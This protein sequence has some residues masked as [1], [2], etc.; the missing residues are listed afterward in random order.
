M[1]LCCQNTANWKATASRVNATESDKDQVVIKRTHNYQCNVCGTS[2]SGTSIKKIQES[3]Y[4]SS[5]N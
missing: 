5:R 1:R 2:L 4:A 3:I